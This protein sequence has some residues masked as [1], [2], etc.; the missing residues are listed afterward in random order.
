MVSVVQVLE[1]KWGDEVE[2]LGPAPDVITGADV[3]YEQEHFPALLKTIQD[4]S[5]VHTVTLLAF[6]MRGLLP[7][8]CLACPLQSNNSPEQLLLPIRSNELC[9]SV[10]A[11][12]VKMLTC[13]SAY[14]NTS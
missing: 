3:L 13:L 5:A 4:L 6:R 9:C 8:P 7:F 11:D 1:H 14:K 12:H 2:S 10:R